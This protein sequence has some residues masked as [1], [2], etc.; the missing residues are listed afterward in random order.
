MTSMP[1]WADPLTHR[2][3][4][5]VAVGRDLVVM[6]L[7]DIVGIRMRLR[8]IARMM[9]MPSIPVGGDV[10]WPKYPAIRS[11]SK[12]GWPPEEGDA[13][14]V[15]H[16]DPD[17][18]TILCRYVVRD[19]P[20]WGF[21]MVRTQVCHSPVF[22]TF[23][24][25]EKLMQ[26]RMNLP[27]AHADHLSQHLWSERLYDMAMDLETRMTNGGFEAAG[28][29]PELEASLCSKA[30]VSIREMLR[31]PD[32]G[33]THS[34]PFRIT[35]PSPYGPMNCRMMH[36]NRSTGKPVESLHPDVAEQWSRHLPSVIEIHS[37]LPRDKIDLNVTTIV[38]HQ[39]EIIHHDPVDQ[40]IDL[41]RALAAFPWTIEHPILPIQRD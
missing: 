4:T 23:I 14:S 1:P 8:E 34:A 11:D 6:D 33:Y 40:P 41:M 24:V 36:G 18:P 38:P 21:D 9:A 28:P 22:N 19:H 32:S 31:N 26:S 35:T 29:D 30:A 15:I 17:G 25:D 3:T 16:R 12:E 2:D 27:S 5:M 39:T 20:E 10:H 13:N 7:V 37:G